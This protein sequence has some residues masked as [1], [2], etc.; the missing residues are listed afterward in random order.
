MPPKKKK[1]LKINLNFSHSELNDEIMSFLLHE[2]DDDDDSSDDSNS[3]DEAS[4]TSAVSDLEWYVKLHNLH[5]LYH[6]KV[7]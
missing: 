1:D 6:A 7:F 2:S 5:F 4:E 3:G